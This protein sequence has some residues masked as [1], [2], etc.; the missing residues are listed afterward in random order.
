MFAFTA[1]DGIHGNELWITDKTA[2]GTRCFGTSTRRRQRRGGASGVPITV[3]GLAVEASISG[4]PISGEG[5]K[6]T[7]AVVS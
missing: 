2:A 1:N 7:H 4:P 3:S 6:A 5:F